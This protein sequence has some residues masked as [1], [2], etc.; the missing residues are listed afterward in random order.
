MKFVI[1]YNGFGYI[2]SYRIKN[3]VGY[4]FLNSKP[5]GS[6]DIS[7]KAFQAFSLIRYYNGCN[8]CPGNNRACSLNIRIVQTKDNI[9]SCFYSFI[10]QFRIKGI[11]ADRG[12]CNGF[13]KRYSSSNL[14]R[15]G[16]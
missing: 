13:C 14:P 4:N 11:Y 12:F 7:E 16:S 6:F 15:Q 8:P 10:Y 3:R 9:C 5:V 1:A 2:M